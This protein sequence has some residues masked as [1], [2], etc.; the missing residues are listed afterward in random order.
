[1]TERRD[2]IVAAAAGVLRE[3]GPSAMTHRSVAAAAGV[4]LAATTYYFASKEELLAEA[5]DVA[6]GAEVARLTRL[7]DLLDTEVARGGNAAETIARLLASA[8]AAE[9]GSVAT[10][11]EVY[12]AAHRHAVLRPAC[13]RWIR[14]FRE[15]AERAAHRAGARDPVRA[16]SLLV[17]G[18]D[19]LLLRRLAI[20]EQAIEVESFQSELLDLVR[21]ISDGRYD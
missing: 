3:G 20:G 18:V 14:A 6:A 9:Y 2:A 8:L 16:G 7:A 5:L 19:G 15:L 10:K 13:E 4:P 17:A 1:V 11:F 12:L 21:A